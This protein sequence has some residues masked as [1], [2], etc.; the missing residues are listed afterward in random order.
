MPSLFKPKQQAQQPQQM[1]QQPQKVDIDESLKQLSRKLMTAQESEKIAREQAKKAM[2]VN[3][4]VV[5]KGYLATCK[6]AQQQQ[7]FI[8]GQIMM[9]QQKQNQIAT[10]TMAKEQVQLL[11]QFKT[12][13]G[14]TDKV[15]DEFRDV[16]QENQQQQ[17]QVQQMQQ[18]MESQMQMGMDMMDPNGEVDADLQ[19]LQ[20]EIDSERLSNLNAPS[21]KQINQQTVERPAVSQELLDDLV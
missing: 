8:Q 20:Q 5:A 2:A 7:K 19:M 14:D 1:V 9:L 15:M 11:K 18:M 17:M 13:L 16:M 3:N 10:V 12:E 4:Q 21:V 6:Q